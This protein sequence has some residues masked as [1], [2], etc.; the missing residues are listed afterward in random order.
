MNTILV[1]GANSGIGLA[2]VN[3]FLKNGYIVLAHYNSSKEELE[4]IKNNNLFLFQANFNHIE[5][6]EEL[7]I[8]VT[9]ITNKID[10]LVNN[11]A[12]YSV[13]KSFEDLE[14]NSFDE[15]LNINLKAPFLLSKNF[16]ELMKNY[17]SGKIVNISS[18]GVKHGG[19]ALSMFYTISKS[20]LETMTTSIVKE[21][22]KYNI[23]VNTIRVGVTNTKIHNRNT[24]KN[25]TKRINL[26]PLKRMAEPSEIAEYILF[27]SSGKNTFITG[28]TVTIAGGE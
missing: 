25:M 28:S 26:I 11:A 23:L 14:I 24:N 19:S 9:K 7:F 17:K 4:K 3:I 27:L 18:I 10:I 20:A 2:V 15:I 12:L 8:N 5:E 22:S 16:I 1:T 21:A 6:V 13:V